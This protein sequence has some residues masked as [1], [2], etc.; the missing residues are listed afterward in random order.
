M[1]AAIWAEPLTESVGIDIPLILGIDDDRNYTI[2]SS[3]W[4]V[5]V[6]EPLIYHLLFSYSV[7][8]PLIEEVG[9][10]KK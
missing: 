1:L 8:L 7:K 4:A 9:S 2:Y 3:K 5:E 6:D 10:M